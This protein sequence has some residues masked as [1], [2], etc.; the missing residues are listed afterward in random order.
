[1]VLQ[2]GSILLMNFTACM[3]GN[4]I[5][6]PLYHGK[7]TLNPDFATEISHYQ[8]MRF[9]GALRT[10]LMVIEIVVKMIR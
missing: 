4:C 8:L 9:G 7:K 1:V 6:T 5:A 10:K 2:A 3:R